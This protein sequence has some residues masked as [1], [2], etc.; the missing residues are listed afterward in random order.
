MTPEERLADLQLRGIEAAADAFDR[1]AAELEGTVNG[2]GRA[3][4]GAGAHGEQ[5]APATPRRPC[6]QQQP[7]PESDQI[8]QQ[9]L[10]SAAA[11]TID[12]FAGLFQQTFETYVELAQAIVQPPQ[13]GAAPPAPAS[14]V[15][16]FGARPGANA[17]ATVWIHNTTPGHAT[18]VALRLTD[19]TASS[20]ARID[21]SL[22]RFVPGTLDVAAGASGSS[23][24][25]LT[26]PQRVV[27]GVYHGHVLAAGLGDAGLPIRLVVAEPGA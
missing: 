24:L 11:R 12:L 15:L 17:G 13:A 20:G 2:I 4:A 9:Q 22:G 8:G 26:I 19:L 23:M 3:D 18:G 10:R 27:P 6:Q 14:A 5:E 1:L 7:P 21:A 25:S 16:S